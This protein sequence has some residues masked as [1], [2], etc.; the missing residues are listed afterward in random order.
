M[1]KLPILPC[2]EKLELVLF[3]APVLA[4]MVTFLQNCALHRNV[5]FGWSLVQS[6]AWKDVP[7]MTY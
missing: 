4:A 1:M 7:E 3:T 5:V 6:I 2:A